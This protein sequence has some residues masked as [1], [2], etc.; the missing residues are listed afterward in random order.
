MLYIFPGVQ[1]VNKEQPKSTEATISC[2]VT[3]LTQK[4]DGVKWTRADDTQIESGTGGFTIDTGEAGFAGDAQTTILTVPTTETDQDKTYKCL[5][6][7]TEHGET[8]KST[9]V[10]LKVFS[11]LFSFNNWLA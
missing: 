11:K 3:G 1:A 6:T 4:L 7:S 9:T 5:I 8:D 10:H 2:T